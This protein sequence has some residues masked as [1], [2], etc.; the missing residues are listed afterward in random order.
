[1]SLFR[2]S[3][4]VLS[5]PDSGIVQRCIKAFSETI[6]QLLFS[7][8][9]L[10]SRSL[11]V[12]SCNQIKIYEYENFRKKFDYARAHNESRISL[13]KS[14]PSDDSGRLALMLSSNVICI[15]SNSLKIIRHYDPLKARNK[16]VQRF[17]QKVEQLNYSESQPDESISPCLRRR[18][19]DNVEWKS[20]ADNVIKTVTRDYSNELVTDI[21]FT[22]DG[23]HLVVSFLDGFIM[24]CSTSLWDVR[25]LIKYPNGL[26]ARR[27]DFIPF[28]AVDGHQK[29]ATTTNK[30]LLTLTSHDELMLMS[31]ADLNARTLDNMNDL[32]NYTIA[33]NGRLML[34]V[35]E[36]GEVLVFDMEKCLQQT[37]FCEDKA[38]VTEKN[39]NSNQWNDDLGRIQTKVICSFSTFLSAIHEPDLRLTMFASPIRIILVSARGVF[40]L[41]VI[42]I[43]RSFS[44]SLT[45]SP[46]LQSDKF[47]QFNKSGE[48]SL[49]RELGGTFN[50]TSNR[51]SISIPFLGWSRNRWKDVEMWKQTTHF[52]KLLMLSGIE[53]ILY[54]SR[55]TVKIE[56]VKVPYSDLHICYAV[57]WKRDFDYDY[58]CDLVL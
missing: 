9:S 40:H 53:L 48:N 13:V 12:S 56:S 49:P 30:L 17:H 25:K 57:H 26:F 31:F 33:L 19:C 34:N 2:T 50:V 10:D 18:H 5:S 24:L 51:K 39:I 46:L 11:V 37:T 29:N 44:L 4:N 28:T 27:C 54:P 20:N 55:Y 14:I 32:S 22:S 42:T 6:N 38:T 1:M 43:E 21:S 15:L 41:N 16:Y 35:K 58:D 45:P 36:T 23:R 7:T 8:S 52:G 3:S 47:L